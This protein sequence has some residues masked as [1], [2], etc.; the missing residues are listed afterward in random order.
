MNMESAMEDRRSDEVLARI[1]IVDDEP[2]IRESLKEILEDEGYQVLLA[3]SAAEAEA[4]RREQ[5]VDLVLLDIWMPGEDGIS[6]LKRWAARGLEQPVVMMSGHGTVETA[7]EATKLG[8][9]DFIEKP[10]SL[11][12]TL[13]TIDHALEAA[14][15]RQENVDL[16]RQ[17]RPVSAPSGDSI[18]VVHLRQQLERVAQSDSWVL[19]SGPPGSGKEVAA[20]YLHA[21]SRRAKGPFVDLKAAAITQPNIAVELFGS[22]QEGQVHSGRLEQAHRGTLFIDEIADMDLETQARLLSALQEGRLRRV[23]GMVPVQV[24]VRVVAATCRDL[25]A[26]MQA[27]RFREDLY[28]RLNVVPLRVPALA[29]RR[30]DIPLL[31]AEFVRFYGERDGL[32]PRRF[33]P[34]ALEVM[35]HYPWPG[36]VRELQNLVERLLILSEGPEVSGEEV[37]RALGLDNRAAISD[38][39]ADEF[40]GTLK[41]ARDKFERAFIEY[42]LA[43]NGGNIAR[44]AEAVGL[45]RTHLYRKLKSLGIPY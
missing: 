3:A 21:H 4:V 20:R 10:L 35:S 12:K 36:N 41:V 2:D 22:E 29:E 9:Y 27:G 39:E 17:A 11:D 33:S 44:T 32:S 8:A 6:L 43:R 13:L 28:Y 15:L 23:G 7:V 26:E 30:Q 38:M 1:L 14:R 40:S 34:A 24:D 42:H 25:R 45:E 37:E 19:L 31:V 18:A 5:R 16:K